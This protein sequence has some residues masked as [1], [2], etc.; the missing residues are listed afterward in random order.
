MAWATDTDAARH[1]PD[2]ASIDPA[3]LSELLDAA[4]E[5]CVAYAP[6]LPVTDPP[7]PVPASYMLANVYQAREI[8]AASQRGESDVIGF[9]DYAIRARPL[10]A[11][12]KQLLRPKRMTWAV[13]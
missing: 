8:Y 2:A 7:T 1:W 11:A 3:A 13:G 12:V 6:A 9:G 10:T 5:Q 4:Y